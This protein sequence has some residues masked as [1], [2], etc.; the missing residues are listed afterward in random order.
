MDLTTWRV[1]WMK[2]GIPARIEAKVVG[3]KWKIKT[4][5]TCYFFLF[6]CLSFFLLHLPSN[7]ALLVLFRCVVNLGHI[8]SYFLM[9]FGLKRGWKN[10]EK[11]FLSKKEERNVERATRPAFKRPREIKPA[12]TFQLKW[13][14][15]VHWWLLAIK[16]LPS[17]DQLGIA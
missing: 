16:S 8:W 12:Q 17:A 15:F 9:R 1:T 7:S 11:K 3:M 13:I 2:E 14:P 6:N 4:N 5:S 10:V